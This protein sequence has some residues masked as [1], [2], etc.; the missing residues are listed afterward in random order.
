MEEVQSRFSGMQPDAGLLDLLVTLAENIKLLV[1]GPLVAGLCALGLSFMLPP[2][3]QSISILQADQSAASL[4]LT[5]AVLDPVIVALGLSRDGTLESA[6]R[7]LKAQI[8]TAIGRG[9]KL[10]TLTVSAPT[11]QQSQALASALLHQSYEES[12]PK[13]TARTRLETQLAEARTR[14]SNA[15]AAAAGLLKRL[16]PN[17]SNAGAAADMARGYAELLSASGAAQTQISTLETQLEGLSEAQLLQPPTLPEEPSEPKKGL[18]ALA[19]VLAAAV[20]LLLTVFMR[21]TFRTTLANAPAL[22]KVARI[23]QCLGL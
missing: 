21:Q 14:L 9:D 22:E 19:A 1:I 4:M 13:G 10:L 8:K 2:T 11:A 16:E 23:R 12:R 15:Q 20:A 7:Q 5:A 3:Y 18:I 17:G 6:R